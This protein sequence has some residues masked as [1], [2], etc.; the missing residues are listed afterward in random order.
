MAVRVAMLTDPFDRRRDALR[1]VL[2]ECSA[3]IEVRAMRPEAGSERAASGVSEA[4]HDAAPAAGWLARLPFGS[5]LTLAA[6]RPDLIISEDF[7]GPALQAALYRSVSPR[8]R[9]LL[10]A[11]EPPR[12]LGLR[13]RV[14]LGHADGVLADGDAVAQA[15]ARMRPTS[16]I[17][18]LCAPD[19]VADFL[20]CRPG[21]SGQQAHRLVYAGELSPHSGAADLLVCVAAWAEQNPGKPVE[22]WW[23]GEGDLAGVLGAQPLPDTVSQR[24]L[25]RLDP[26]GTAAAFGQCGLLVVPSLT[27]GR[28]APVAQ[29]LAAGLPVLGSR[30][31]REVRRHV[32][33]GVNGWVFDPLQPDDMPR[34][35]AR[36]L[37]C[38]AERL[39]EM[40]DAARARV[41]SAGS[42]GFAER[43]RRAVAAVMPQIAPPE[44][45]P[46][47]AG[48]AAGHAP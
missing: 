32:R 16:R 17:F 18:P 38:P 1:G 36:A 31:E 14:I 26:L 8:S 20:A 11:T 3:G 27:D 12:R 24:F 45:A 33:E 19:E 42:R 13:E 29:A 4:A 9:L 44:T 6:Y 23:I 30:R 21:R 7:G 41:R 15:V 5:V 22:I 35:L 48:A 10:C 40:R 37:A 39:D 43:F 34:A 46:A 28:R 2:E 47:E 25:G